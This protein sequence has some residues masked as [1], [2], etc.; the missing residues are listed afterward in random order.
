MPETL[1]SI[2]IPTYNRLIELKVTL[3]FLLFEIE[4]NHLVNVEVIISD[5]CSD[6]GTLPYLEQLKV[7]HPCLN[8]NINAENIGMIPNWKK[9]INLATG[10]YVW[11]LGSDDIIIPGTLPTLIREL[12]N[13]PDAHLFLLNNKI[14]FP[15][16]DEYLNFDD[17]NFITTESAICDDEDS[18]VPRVAMFVGKR[19]DLFTPIYL[20]IMKKKDW[21][22][23]L[24]LYDL[25]EPFFSSIYNSVPQAVYISKRLFDNEGVYIQ[26][27]AVLASYT[28]SWKSFASLYKCYYLPLLH[29]LWIKYGADHS[30]VNKSLKELM[31]S[32]KFEHFRDLFIINGQN[33]VYFDYF[34]FLRIT[35]R[36][37]RAYLFISYILYLNLLRLIKLVP[38]VKL[39]ASKVKFYRQRIKGE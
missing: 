34:D 24:E 27:P 6:D 13:H 37:K 17:R 5:N 12:Q 19:V 18:F 3:K 36:Y 30:T 28:V 11:L 35:Y 39:L 22:N 8:V 9:A 26:S 7:D 4:D 38:G 20:S 23:A 32:T 25:E 2:C 10:K 33:L 15:Q 14:W 29:D 16:I 21:H 1:L 31:A